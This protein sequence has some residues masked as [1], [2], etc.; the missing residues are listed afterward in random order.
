MKLL[1]VIVAVSK[2]QFDL[3]DL[4]NFDL[5]AFG[6]GPGTPL[7][8]PDDA[9][10]EERYFFTTTTTTSTTTTTTTTTSIS[11]G[12]TCWKCDQMTYANCALKGSYEQCEMGDEDCC[13]VEIR[14]QNQKL[15][16]LCTGCKDATACM[17]NMNENFIGNFNTFQCRSDYRLQRRGRNQ[18]VQ[19]VCRQCFSTCVIAGPSANRDRCFGSMQDDTTTVNVHFT[20]ATHKANLPWTVHYTEADIHGFGIPTYAVADG[21]TDAAVITAIGTNFDAGTENLWF[22]DVAAGTTDGKINEGT[23][24]G[25]RDTATE[26]VYW[27]LQGAPLSWWSNSLKPIQNTLATV[28]GTVNA[29]TVANFNP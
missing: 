17:D 10:N 21:T 11:F 5:S 27:G 24:D 2:A 18:D 4:S 12:D 14:E 20:L 13:F 23:A 25:T 6:L 15:A 3:P 8:F 22:R 29:F 19:S 28:G 16:Q 1:P 7:N 26:M 9:G